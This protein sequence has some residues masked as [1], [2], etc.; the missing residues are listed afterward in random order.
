[1]DPS[2]GLEFCARIVFFVFI[3]TSRQPHLYITTRSEADAV[4]EVIYTLLTI[5]M[6]W[7][8]SK[9][10]KAKDIMNNLDTITSWWMKVPI[11]K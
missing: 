9:T 1:M 11:Y 2:M 10:L 4:T 3:N 7:L 5:N 8:V 6:L